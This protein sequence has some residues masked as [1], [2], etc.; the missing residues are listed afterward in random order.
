MPQKYPSLLLATF[1]AR[2][3]GWFGLISASMSTLGA[4]PHCWSSAKSSPS[5]EGTRGQGAP[6]C[7]PRHLGN[8][9]VALLTGILDNHQIINSLLG[10][11]MNITQC[12]FRN[13]CFPD[14]RVAHLQFCQLFYQG[15]HRGN[16]SSCLSALLPGIFLLEGF[17]KS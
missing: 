10:D 2:S 17:L 16:G 3:H 6:L 8:V 13:V 15:L 9:S 4:F 7:C 1:A 12:K 14:M 5:G 11:R